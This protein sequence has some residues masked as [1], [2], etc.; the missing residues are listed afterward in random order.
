MSGVAARLMP[1]FGRCVVQKVQPA[2]MSKG[3]IYIP[4]SVSQQTGC[5]MAKVVAVAPPKPSGNVA[6]SEDWSKLQVG[7]T[8]MVPEFGGIKVQLEEE[9]LFV[10]RGEDILAVVKEQ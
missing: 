3:G 7:Q 1:I 9:E 5:H 6:V 8:V 10:F 4:S 2:A